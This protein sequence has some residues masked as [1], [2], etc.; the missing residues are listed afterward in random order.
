VCNVCKAGAAGL[1]QHMLRMVWSGIAARSTIACPVNL[2]A[3]KTM[4]EP[5]TEA[6]LR[7]VLARIADHAIN[8]IDGLAP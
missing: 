2:D 3:P 7:F 4:T 8:R 1:R 5:I 6:Y